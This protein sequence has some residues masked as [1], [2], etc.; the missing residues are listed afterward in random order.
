M[1]AIAAEP[2]G[3]AE[4]SM[5]RSFAV[6]LKIVAGVTEFSKCCQRAGFFRELQYE[7]P[8]LRRLTPG[9]PGT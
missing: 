9:S 2:T 3:V 4:R 5:L 7:I 1:F 8:A 6:A